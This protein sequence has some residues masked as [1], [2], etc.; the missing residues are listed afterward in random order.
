M[1]TV[2]HIDRLS[3][4]NVFE[5]R[6]THYQPSYAEIGKPLLKD[7][8]DPGA[9]LYLERPDGSISPETVGGTYYVMNSEGR[10]IS[11]YT[12]RMEPAEP[13]PAAA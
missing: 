13:I 7:E 12:I 2:K 6:R 1:L 4:E 5:V 11:K 8:T 3:H 9:T 10:T